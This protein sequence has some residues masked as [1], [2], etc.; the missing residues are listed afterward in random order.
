MSIKKKKS[1]YY[2]Y[3]NKGDIFS[4]TLTM[5]CVSDADNNYYC[6]KISKSFITG[7]Y[8]SNNTSS[9]SCSK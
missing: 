3:G 2:I 5:L 7:F 1:N 4:H 9:C 8:K 6:S